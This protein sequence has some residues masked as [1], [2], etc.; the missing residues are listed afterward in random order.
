MK[1]CMGTRMVASQVCTLQRNVAR[2]LRLSACPDGTITR[3]SDV[4]RSVKRT[5]FFPGPA[6]PAAPGCT[7][8]GKDTLTSTSPA[9]LSSGLAHREGCAL[10]VAATGVH[11]LGIW[12]ISKG[13]TNRENKRLTR[14]IVRLASPHWRKGNTVQKIPCALPYKEYAVFFFNRL[15]PNRYI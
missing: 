10:R 2:G 15:R 5:L 13:S 4:M 14:L 9:C 11:S 3:R 12:I 8:S 1:L 6:A 7:V